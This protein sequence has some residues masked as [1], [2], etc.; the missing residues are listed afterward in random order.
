MAKNINQNNIFKLQ[1]GR[2]KRKRKRKSFESNLDK[3]IKI[4]A[5]K[6]HL[7]KGGYNSLIDLR[8][9]EFKSTGRGMYSKKSVIK[10]NPLIEMPY[11]LMITYNVIVESEVV[12]LIKSE[13]LK[14]LTMHDYLSLFLVLEK[15]K[16]DFSSWK[17][18]LDTLPSDLPCL[19]WFCEPKEMELLPCDLKATFVA[20]RYCFEESWYRV[21]KSMKPNWKC[22]CC[23]KPP[24]CVFDFNAFR[25]GY[26][27]VNTRSVYVDPEVVYN[28]LKN[29]ANVFCSGEPSM[30]MCPFLDMFNHSNDAKTNVCFKKVDGQYKFILNTEVRFKKYEQLFIKYGVYDNVKLLLEYGFF[31][32]FNNYDVVQFTFEE[33]LSWTKLYACNKTYVYI[34]KNELIKNLYIS[35]SGVSF[36]LKALL[37]VLLTED[38][39]KWNSIVFN[40]NYNEEATC[41]IKLEVMKILKVK[42]EILKCDV[43]RLFVGSCS[44]AC[45]NILDFMKYRV[46]FIHKL[47]KFVESEKF[48]L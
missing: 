19:P 21:K 7:K 26:V 6:Q 3:D 16:N 2:T 12:N 41:A 15:H 17:W 39:K 14:L 11:E 5:M 45:K 1:M 28:T 43:E 24:D 34:C 44:V 23:K 25:W 27:L 31:L 8:L 38:F 29:G 32:P 48:V 35:Y 20:G 47:L 42:M 9:R 30:G 4:I 22:L 10:N 13:H 46:L 33:V 36:K 18:Y 40:E 37:Y